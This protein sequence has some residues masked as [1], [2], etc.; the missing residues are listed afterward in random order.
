MEEIYL[1]N[2]ELHLLDENALKN[3][4]K[5]KNLTLIW[6]KIRELPTNFI[7]NQLELKKI[8]LGSNR[9]TSLPSSLKKQ[10]YLEELILYGNQISTLPGDFFDSFT[11]L[12]DLNLNSNILT[13]LNPSWFLNLGN[14]E[15]IYL[16]GNK[17][18]ELPQKV[19]APLKKLKN[20]GIMDNQLTVICADSFGFLTNLKRVF[21]GR[22]QINAI[23][24]AFID[25]NG[26]TEIVMKYGNICSQ[27]DVKGSKEDIKQTLIKCFE[28]YRELSSK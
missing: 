13:S 14:L 9:L 10:I 7:H 15:N 17:I 19:F 26:I 24:E 23:E 3:C 5:L 6:G 2:V 27:E 8:C 12:R 1:D 22:N 25:N 16:H 4:Q 20:L 18:R 28:N 11:K 21:F